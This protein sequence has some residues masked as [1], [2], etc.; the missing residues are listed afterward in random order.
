[1]L[2][3]IMFFLSGES[4]GPPPCVIVRCGRKGKEELGSELK[5][6]QPGF[7]C[8][9]VFTPNTPACHM[10]VDRCRTIYRE[11]AGKNGK[12]KKHS[13]QSLR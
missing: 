8:G 3:V 12:E 5:S 4:R 10:A 6:S 9:S 2:V 7:V 1:M 13:P 11:G